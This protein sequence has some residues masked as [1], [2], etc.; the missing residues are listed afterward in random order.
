[1]QILKQ[2]PKS[3]LLLLKQKFM[4]IYYLSFSSYDNWI[5]FAHLLHMWLTVSRSWCC[6]GDTITVEKRRGCQKSV[7]IICLQAETLLNQQKQRSKRLAMQGSS[8][9][10]I[11]APLGSAE[12]TVSQFGL[13]MADA[14]DIGRL[15][16]PKF[17][18]ALTRNKVSEWIYIYPIWQFSLW[19][20]TVPKQD[21]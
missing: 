21:K 14:V 8:S 11:T 18:A 9:L 7:L 2:I 1:M 19:N 15:F 4:Q 20:L 16:V 5:C 10:Q 3:C 12:L 17:P 13:W 6:W